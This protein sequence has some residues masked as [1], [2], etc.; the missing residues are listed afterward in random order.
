MWAIVITW[1]LLIIRNMW[2]LSSLIFKAIL[3]LR[4]PPS[5]D[6]FKIGLWKKCEIIV[7]VLN[8]I[9]MIDLALNRRYQFQ[10]FCYGYSRKNCYGG[11]V[12]PIKLFSLNK[13]ID[14]IKN[15]NGFEIDIQFYISINFWS[16]LT[17]KIPAGIEHV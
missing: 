13:K 17:K 5:L 9:S 2:S 1:H 6:K 8:T 14:F 7:F 12:L 10:L 16:L 4:W 11:N 15:N 3:N